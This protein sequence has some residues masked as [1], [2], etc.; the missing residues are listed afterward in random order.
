MNQHN[1]PPYKEMKMH[2]VKVSYNSMGE[3]VINQVNFR[4]RISPSRRKRRIQ[5]NFKT[6]DSN[7]LMYGSKE[8][9]Y[10]VMD[11][12]KTV[13][14]L[15]EVLLGK[16][17]RD[18]M[19]SRPWDEC[20]LSDILRF[21]S[22][23][24]F[25]A[26][27]IAETRQTD[28]FNAVLALQSISP[29]LRTMKRL[30]EI[31]GMKN[32]AFQTNETFY[33]M[34]SWFLINDAIIDNE[35]QLESD[36]LNVQNHAKVL[37]VS[38]EA[39]LEC[40]LN[41]EKEPG[42]SF[43]PKFVSTLKQRMHSSI[44]CETKQISASNTDT[45]L[46]LD[47]SM[48]L[49]TLLLEENNDRIGHI[50]NMLFRQGV[51]FEK[52]LTPVNDQIYSQRHLCLGDI[53]NIHSLHNI[54]EDLNTLLD[55]CIV[56]DKER[57]G[58]IKYKDFKSI[59]LFWFTRVSRTE[60]IYHS[61]FR[62]LFNL[63][64]VKEDTSIATA[65]YI[66]FVG[67]IYTIVLD[68]HTIPS[69]EGILMHVN[70]ATR[71]IDLQH[72]LFLT[73]YVEHINL[74]KKAGENATSERPRTEDPRQSI[75]KLDPLPESDFLSRW[76]VLGSFRNEYHDSVKESLIVSRKVSQLDV[77]QS[78]NR[79][80]GPRPKTPLH[81]IEPEIC[82]DDRSF[83]HEEIYHPIDSNHQGFSEDFGVAFNESCFI[84]RSTDAQK[85]ID[86]AT[87][88]LTKHCYTDNSIHDE[89][90]DGMSSLHK[91]NTNNNNDER[92]TNTNFL[93]FPIG[94]G[95]FRG[96]T[97]IENV[98]HYSS[99]LLSKMPEADSEEINEKDDP[100]SYTRCTSDYN[101]QEL[102]AP[103]KEHFRRSTGFSKL[104]LAKNQINKSSSSGFKHIQTDI[105]N[106]L[107][108]H[109][110]TDEGQTLHPQNDNDSTNF[111]ENDISYDSLALTST[112]ITSSL[113]DDSTP[114]RKILYKTN[115]D[116]G[117]LKLEKGLINHNQNNNTAE[118]EIE[119][120]EVRIDSS[121]S[122]VVDNNQKHLHI[123]YTLEGNSR[124]QSHDIKSRKKHPTQLWQTKV[125]TNHSYPQ[126]I[127]TP[128]IDP[129]QN[130]RNSNAIEN[131]Q[132][133][134]SNKCSM[135]Q[136]YTNFDERNSRDHVPLPNRTSAHFSSQYIK[137]VC[138][139]N[140]FLK[141]AVLSFRKLIELESNNFANRKKV[142]RFLTMEPISNQWGIDI[143]KN[144]LSRSRQTLNVSFVQN[145]DNK[146]TISMKDIDSDMHFNITISNTN[147]KEDT[148]CIDAVQNKIDQKFMV[149][150]RINET[151]QFHTHDKKYFSHININLM[152]KYEWTHLFERNEK[153]LL[154]MVSKFHSIHDNLQ[155]FRNR[156]IPD[157]IELGTYSTCFSILNRNNNI[158]EFEMKTKE[159]L[160]LVTSAYNISEDVLGVGVK[161]LLHSSRTR[162][163]YFTG[164][165][166]KS[167]RPVKYRLR[168]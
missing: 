119:E 121:T 23:T 110:N 6:R 58:L 20:P 167:I 124:D 15:R 7:L 1:R 86:Y 54:L 52:I 117:L 160:P 49:L 109:I 68:E 142:E 70:G 59:V 17:S 89:G 127:S 76:L 140:N 151:S 149:E 22:Q 31:P 5:P 63:F 103:R 106:T 118:I 81:I 120:R 56:L 143:F 107:D 95:K 131:Y 83:V 2:H 146:S 139:G 133:S 47:E 73:E 46:D 27:S 112:H 34:W 78:K 102:W 128:M 79:S 164:D 161:S 137:S 82:F 30:L 33:H 3:A 28:L 115:F 37:H 84:L 148:T 100:S 116:T 144:N 11:L 126:I 132:T 156:F 4:E 162:K 93:A 77:P 135:L 36:E 94:E 16:I 60:T 114:T 154:S 72:Y 21:F 98:R 8:S 43:S 96:R 85:G 130:D 44:K 134:V 9:T 147:S 29:F 42:S 105:K 90:R 97:I 50:K 87:H 158:L 138:V 153:N 67:V 123:N 168:R 91:S 129:I 111:L 165:T 41:I 71:G 32:F 159:N 66:D 64:E 74:S 24:S 14:L 101:N 99:S 51:S 92:K 26:T 18:I 55:K 61:Q 152:N 57:R 136:N 10:T 35:L 69:I 19:Y 12:T 125:G 141:A 38:E 157:R 163:Q 40:L 39:F 166:D 80:V 150:K 65:N 108:H 25:G 113:G 13:S 155:L 53:G 75:T 145:E 48:E 104:N 122:T 88:P 62:K 45:C